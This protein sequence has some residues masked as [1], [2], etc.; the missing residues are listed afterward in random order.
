MLFNFLIFIQ[1]EIYTLTYIPNN[2]YKKVIFRFVY[3]TIYKNKDCKNENIKNICR[4]SLFIYEIVK[5][6]KKNI[7][8]IIH[9]LLQ[10]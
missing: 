9:Y 10:N 8:K 3:L 1:C 4:T 5:S 6:T 2:I 7:L